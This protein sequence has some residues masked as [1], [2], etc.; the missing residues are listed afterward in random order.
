MGGRNV[1]APIIFFSHGFFLLLLTQPL[2]NERLEGLRLFG[3]CPGSLLSF[4]C[5]AGRVSYTPEAFLKLLL[6]VLQKPRGD[7]PIRSWHNLGISYTFSLMQR[8]V[9]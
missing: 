3:H 2:E 6:K 4:K 7:L 5:I 1:K 8:A 9:V